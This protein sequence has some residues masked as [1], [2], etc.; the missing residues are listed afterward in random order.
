[1]KLVLF[2]V[3]S[4]LLFSGCG[5]AQADKIPGQ[6]LE[7]IGVDHV[8]RMTA[9]K[10]KKI[11]EYEL[12][13][14]KSEKGKSYRNEAEQEV[15]KGTNEGI[16]EKK[17]N[18]QEA[19]EVAK[20]RENKKNQE[21]LKQ[22]TRK[23]NKEVPMEDAQ[24]ENNSTENNTHDEN[25]SQPEYQNNKLSGPYIAKWLPPSL[26]EPRQ[27]EITHIVIHFSSNALH[28]PE[29]PFNVD[30]LYRIFLEAG[31]STH[32]LIDREGKIYQL[33]EEELAAWHAGKG[34]LPGF[35]EYTNRLNHH[36]IGIELLAIG[37]E[38][39]MKKINPQIDYQSIDP[40]HIGFT[41]SQYRSLSTLIQE[42]ISRH[43]N[44]T[45]DRKHII[46]HDEYT[47]R[48]SDPGTLFDWSKIGL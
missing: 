12:E 40:A 21:Q 3:A 8:I 31:V 22:P 23:N 4:L 16:Q 6:R 35:P 38:E 41:D 17:T 7:Q 25:H 34:S 47:D 29:D 32:Y 10:D 19:K 42:I 2:L 44:I 37:T 48:K 26:T 20:H 27:G 5:K 43:P 46:G 18:E 11:L 9:V 36:S 1:M 45:F 15:K 39:E 24:T 28:K 14:N 33:V 30:D 13:N